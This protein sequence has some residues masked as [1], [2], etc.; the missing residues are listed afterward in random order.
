MCNAV[1][2]ISLDIFERAGMKEICKKRDEL[3]SYLEF[4]INE[5]SSAT[6]GLEIEIITPTEI[7][8]R[9]AQLSLLAHKSGKEIFDRLTESG[10]IADWRE[11][12]VIRIAPAPLY[13]SFYDVYRFGQLLI[14]AA[15]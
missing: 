2:K 5:V 11:P 8:K 7:A 4:V 14:K 1:H 13:N 12:N 6:E 3:T 9:G 15:S 10:V